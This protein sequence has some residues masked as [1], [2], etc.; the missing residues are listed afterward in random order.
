MGKILKQLKSKKLNTKNTVSLQDF[1]EIDPNNPEELIAFQK[2][3]LLFQL[4][5]YILKHKIT[6]AELAKRLGITRQAVTNKFLGEALTMDW[7]IRAFSV[8]GIGL[9]VKMPA[10]VMSAA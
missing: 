1:L 5:E 6:K 2:H 3:K 9:E 7:I 8:L 4:H 10:H